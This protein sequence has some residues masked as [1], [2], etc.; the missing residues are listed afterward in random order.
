MDENETVIVRTQNKIKRE[1]GRGRIS[2][3]SKPQ[4]KTYSVSF[5]KWRRLND[6]TSL[7]FGYTNGEWMLTEYS[8]PVSSVLNIRSPV[9]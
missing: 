4:N 6:N 2:I 3:I 9:I 5:L 8:W 1:R 7:P